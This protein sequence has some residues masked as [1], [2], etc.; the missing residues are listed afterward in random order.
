MYNSLLMAGKEN[1]STAFQEFIKASE[2]IHLAWSNLQNDPHQMELYR[3]LDK[4]SPDFVQWREGDP[5]ACPLP[6]YVLAIAYIQAVK[7]FERLGDFK[8]GFRRGET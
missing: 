4:S 3:K 7:K 6:D 5:I 2:A 1:C 8:S